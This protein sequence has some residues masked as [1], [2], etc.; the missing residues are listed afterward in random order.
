M[1]FASIFDRRG[2]ATHDRFVG[3]LSPGPIVRAPI[4]DQP[5][6]GRCARSWWIGHSSVDACEA[7][8]RRVAG[9]VPDRGVADPGVVL[10]YAMAGARLARIL[11]PV[12]CHV[13]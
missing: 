1:F 4:V 2:R 9:D 7:R 10:W 13:W 11:Q 3:G 5:A 12:H 8:A 6:G